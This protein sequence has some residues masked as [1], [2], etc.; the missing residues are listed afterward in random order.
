MDANKF[1]YPYQKAY[2]EKIRRNKMNI[3]HHR[4]YQSD[5]T[6]DSCTLLHGMY[7]AYSTTGNFSIRYT[8]A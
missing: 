5:Y 4:E 3:K 6:V 8:L 7:K 2:L 1:P